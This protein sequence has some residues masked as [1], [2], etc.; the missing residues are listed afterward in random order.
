MM[1]SDSEQQRNLSSLGKETDP[2]QVSVER[3]ASV[4]DPNFFQQWVINALH[5][6][7]NFKHRYKRN[8]PFQLNVPIRF[9]M[10]FLLATVLVVVGIAMITLDQRT[11]IW[12][13]ELPDSYKLFFEI[14]TDIG[15]SNWILLSTGSF[16]IVTL[17]FDWSKFIPRTKM[18]MS[19]IWFYAGFIFFVVAFSGIISLMFK[20]LLGRARPNQN[21]ELGAVHFDWFRV[22]FDFNSFP[23]GHSTTIA[24]LGTALCL[25]FPKLL[26]YVIFA[27]FWLV[28][29]RIMVSA[30]YPSDV[31]AGTLLGIVV[32]LISARYLASHGIG[33]R[34]VS[35]RGALSLQNSF[36]LSSINQHFKL[37]KS[38]SKV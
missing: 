9:R 12:V 13:R 15:K 27:G 28:L 6:I 26:W 1:N 35:A 4:V 2:S 37:I 10:Q 22:T 17:F 3:K 31:I 16:M 25:L 21:E 11:Y 19:A 33:F 34:L 20:A 29:S 8:L 5:V 32:T 38:K 14:I 24:S 23:S 30:H 7:R 18:M 36:N